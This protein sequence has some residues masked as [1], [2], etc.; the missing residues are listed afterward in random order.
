MTRS[1]LP[2][3]FVTG[4][5]T[6]AAPL[7]AQF[8][9]GGAPTFPAAPAAPA[10]SAGGVRLGMPVTPP[11]TRHPALGNQPLLDPSGQPVPG[12]NG[13]A[14][15]QMGPMPAPPDP[16]TAGRKLAGKDLKR[17]VKKVAALQWEKKLDVALAKAAATGKPVLWLQA[18]GDLDGFA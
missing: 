9:G 6:L 5:L 11:P 13:G 4:V 2:V 15:P 7:A 1:C 14:A 12:Q 17:A 10:P 8:R 3:V 16:A 18:L